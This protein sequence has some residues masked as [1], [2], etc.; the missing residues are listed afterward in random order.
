MVRNQARV[1]RD[2]DA[3][4]LLGEIGGGYEGVMVVEALMI[5][6]GRGLLISVGS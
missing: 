5:G 4:S 1:E 6:D 2:L 3:L